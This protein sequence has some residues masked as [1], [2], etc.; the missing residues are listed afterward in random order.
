MGVSMD[1][2]EVLKSDHGRIFD[3]IERLENTS[4]RSQNSRQQDYSKFKKELLQHMHGEEQ[5]FYPFLLENSRDKELI[6]QA[7]EEHR[8][9]R[10]VMPD[11]ETTDIND[12]QWISR[13]KVVGEM[14]RHHIDQEEENT[15]EIANEVVDKQMSEELAEDYQTAKEETE[16]SL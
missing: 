1:I 13:M 7:M 15:F 14:V 10:L 4:E 3:L 6:Y 2:F 5:T 9:I 16:I 8:A 11:L 12:E